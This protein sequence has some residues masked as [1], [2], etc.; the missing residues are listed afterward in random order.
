[1]E[2]WGG[3]RRSDAD[4]RTRD[5]ASDQHL[6]ATSAVQIGFA[7]H[8]LVTASGARQPIVAIL[9][10]ISLFTVTSGKPIDGL[11]L[12]S[13]A[14]ALAWDAGISARQAPAAG[15][16]T[17]ARPDQGEHSPLSAWRLRTGRPRL[18]HLVLGLAA[19]VTYSLTVG[20]FTRY[21]WPTTASVAGLGAGVVV[22]GW[23]G[24][25]RH[26]DVPGRFSRLGVL[27]WGSILV[28]GSLWELGAL[29]GQ[30]SLAVSSYAHPTISTLTSP[31]LHSSLGR[32]AALL[33]WIGLGAFL[34]ER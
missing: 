28:T 18:R 16:V 9:L 30:P 10:L 17:T 6:P 25:T 19:A 14:T 13:V 2:S 24:P 15:T 34:V 20:S 3:P 33:G 4:R 26:R 23:G 32:S 7:D 22:V 12:A 27:T 29:L 1:M 5:P 8:V 11:L 21:S 31:L